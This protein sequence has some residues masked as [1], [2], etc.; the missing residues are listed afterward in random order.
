[1]AGTLHKYIERGPGA[2]F[3]NLTLPSGE[4]LFLALAKGGLSL[5][6]LYLRGFI[7]RARD[8]QGRR[9]RRRARRPFP[10]A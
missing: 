9:S 1:M 4:R 10:G 5:H 8:P 7:S 2:G 3:A 6:P